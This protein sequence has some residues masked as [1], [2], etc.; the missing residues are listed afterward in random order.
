MGVIHT[1]LSALSSY[2]LML[3]VTA[4]NL[5]N[6]NTPGFKSQ[7]LHFLDTFYQTLQAPPSLSVAVKAAK[8]QFR[9]E[10]AWL[11]GQL[12][13]EWLR[14]FH[15]NRHAH[16]HDHYWQRLLRCHKERASSLHPRWRFPS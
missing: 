2:D 1:A 13:P 4:N 6:L 8:T 9:L 12:S 16:R 15:P 14:D 11:S 3:Q 7:S 5:A 10:W